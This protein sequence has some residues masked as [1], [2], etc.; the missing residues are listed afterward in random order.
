[1]AI[2]IM[3]AASLLK[4]LKFV[5]AGFTV[6]GFEM[7]LLLLGIVVSFAVSLI[8]IEFLMSFV[9]KH[10]FKPFGVYR[11]VLGLVVIGYFLIKSFM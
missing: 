2:P 9:K 8:A 11:I 4:I 10:D 5:L 6:S 7:I 3:L 1:M